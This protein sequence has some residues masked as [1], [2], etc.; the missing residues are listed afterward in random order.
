MLFLLSPA[1]SLD[2]ESPPVRSPLAHTTPQFV[3]Q[4]KALIDV[5]RQATP[6]QIASLM[7]LSDKLATLNVARY[8]AWSSRA[9]VKN[10]RQ[11]VLALMAMCMVGW[12]P[13]ACC[14]RP[15]LGAATPVHP[16]WLVRRVA[17][18]GPD[19]ALP[20]GDG[21]APGHPAG[22]DLYAFWGSRIAEYLK[23]AARRPQPGGG[24]PGVAGVFQGRG[25]QRAESTGC[26]VCSKKAG[27][28]LQVVSFFAKRARGF[29]GALCHHAS[30]GAAGA[31]EG[32]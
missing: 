6:A 24:E 16:Q 18:A 4:S 27:R 11:A 25:P 20:P 15:G 31:V 32:L 5:L 23:P 28:H 17:P 3:A 22:K 19:A 12:M 8:Q 10:A 21:H 26:G 14:R 2:Y 30:A 7:A 9:T 29:D 1:K 13:V